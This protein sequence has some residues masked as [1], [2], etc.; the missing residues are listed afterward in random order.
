MI[1]ITQEKRDLITQV[2]NQNTNYKEHGLR[3]FDDIPDKAL[4]YF[5]GMLNKKG[6]QLAHDEE[7]VLFK[8]FT[9][10]KYGREGLLI[11]NQNLY[12]KYHLYFRAVKLTDIVALQ[13]DPYDT[14][15]ISI[16]LKDGSTVEVYAS[17]LYKEVKEIMN[18]LLSGTGL[19]NEYDASGNRVV[20]VASRTLRSNRT[21]SRIYGVFEWI[22]F[23]FIGLVVAYWMMDMYLYQYATG[24]DFEI[25]QYHDYMIRFMDWFPFT[26][27]QIYL[28]SLL[29]TSGFLITTILIRRFGT[30]YKKKWRF[31]FDVLRCIFWLAIDVVFLMMALGWI[32]QVQLW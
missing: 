32:A 29:I 26:S 25:H 6:I 28:I 23:L 1:E 15:N 20:D 13:I 2:H 16:A 5:K 8:D 17:E 27:V 30:F 24:I 11:T 4:T 14:Y 18:I 10:L 31:V 22:D 9:W 12:F 7:I 21:L 3:I 19:E